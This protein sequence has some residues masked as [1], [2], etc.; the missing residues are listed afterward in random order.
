MSAER[1]VHTMV[2]RWRRLLARASTLQIALGLLAGLSMLAALPLSGQR[3]LLLSVAAVC[4]LLATFDY[5]MDGSG[6]DPHEAVLT[7]HTELMADIKRELHLNDDGWYVPTEAGE[8]RRWYASAEVTASPPPVPIPAGTFHDGETAGVSVPTVGWALVEQTQEALPSGDADEAI[9]EALGLCQQTGL[10]TEWET[11]R[12]S[13][14]ENAE[15]MFDI[16]VRATA[17][18]PEDSSDDFAMSL[19]GTVV[20]DITGRPVQ[21]VA[22]EIERRPQTV[23]VRVLSGEQLMPS[24]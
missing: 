2:A 4:L 3:A 6:N 13:G 9:E 23:T 16:R 11:E 19:L 5:A 17:G 22:D 24:S 8:V 15:A 1:G 21:V 12:R 7:A 10:V 14:D 20:A 18:R